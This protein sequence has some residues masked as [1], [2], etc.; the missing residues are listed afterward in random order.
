MTPR[1]SILLA[2]L[3]KAARMALDASA[4]MDHISHHL[5]GS[6]ARYNWVGFYLVDKATPRSL[7][8]GPHAGSF[9][10]V[11]RISF[12]QALCAPAADTRKSLSATQAP[13]H[14]PY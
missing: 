13:T 3:E 8:L 14:T 10:P 2:D 5:H 7:V 12:D 11:E 1:Q 6:V 4:L 9:T